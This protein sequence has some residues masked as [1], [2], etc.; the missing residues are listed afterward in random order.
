MDKPDEAHGG[1]PADASGD[2]VDST[3]ASLPAPTGVESAE[4]AVPPVDD[5]ESLNPSST[6]VPSS[7]VA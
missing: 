1:V 6:S 7:F 4:S 3:A 5:V 2:D